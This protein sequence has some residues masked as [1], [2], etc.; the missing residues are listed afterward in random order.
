[1]DAPFS[2]NTGGK[3]E[4]SPAGPSPQGTSRSL[5]T[6]PLAPPSHRHGVGT[7]MK[8][9][10]NPR[11][12]LGL[13]KGH[14]GVHSEKKGKQKEKGESCL[15]LQQFRQMQQTWLKVKPWP[16]PREAR[17]GGY[18]DA[19]VSPPLGRGCLGSSSVDPRNL[20]MSPWLPLTT[21]LTQQTSEKD[22]RHKR[23]PAWWFRRPKAFLHP[24]RLS[25]YLRRIPPR[26]YVVARLCP[27]FLGVEQATQTSKKQINRNT[28][29]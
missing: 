27:A 13:A 12:T 25:I 4:A 20:S 3:T 5:G 21:F 6:P 29:R 24:Y 2:Q 10:S 26:P 9:A 15:T 16:G 18:K 19:S 11:P 8:G 1:M 17:G 14:S 23:V 28:V 7:D 22:R